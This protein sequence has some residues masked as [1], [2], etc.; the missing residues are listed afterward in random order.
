MTSFG[1]VWMMAFFGPIAIGLIIFG[2]AV[3]AGYRIW[4]IWL[5]GLPL[6]SIG[7]WLARKLLVG[8]SL[9]RT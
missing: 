5:I 8:N 3:R 7:S 4:A 9:G 2:F 6:I 1:I